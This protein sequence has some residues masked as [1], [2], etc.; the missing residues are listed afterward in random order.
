MKK[1]E[2][3]SGYAFIQKCKFMNLVDQS[4]SSSGG[5]IFI[6]FPFNATIDSCY[7]EKCQSLTMGGAIFVA[8]TLNGSR[9]D[10]LKISNCQFVDCSSKDKGGAITSAY[11]TSWGDQ[12]YDGDINLTGCLFKNCHS[13]LGGALYFLNGQE[14]DDPNKYIEHCIFEDCSGDNEEG[15][16]VYSLAYSISFISTTFRVTGDNNDRKSIFVKMDESEQSPVFDNC[17]FDHCDGFY[18]ETLNAPL[19]M[20]ACT[21]IQASVTLKNFE[22]IN[23]ITFNNC[24]FRDNKDRNSIEI[25]Q[26]SDNQVVNVIGCKFMNNHNENEVIWENLN[27]GCFLVFT[28]NILIMT[29]KDCEFSEIVTKYAASLHVDTQT[30]TSSINLERCNFS[31]CTSLVD[32]KYMLSHGSLYLKARVK[33]LIKHCHFVECTSEISGGAITTEFTGD[34]AGQQNNVIDIKECTF[35]SCHSQRGGAIACGEASDGDSNII[36]C[37]F[38]NC[39]ASESGGAIY[40]KNT[41]ELQLYQDVDKSIVNCTFD[42][43]YSDGVGSAI[44]SLAFNTSLVNN[45]FIN[46][47][48]KSSFLYLEKD[49]VTEPVK[50]IECIFNDNTAN[51]YIKINR[52]FSANFIRCLFMQSQNIPLLVLEKENFDADEIIFDQCDFNKSMTT[53]VQVLGGR[54]TFYK[55]GFHDNSADNIS[56]LSIT[57][58]DEKDK[59]KV[60]KCKFSNNKAKTNGALYIE[61]YAEILSGAPVN[62]SYCNF[63]NNQCDGDGGAASLNLNGYGIETFTNNTFLENQAQNGGAI[64]AQFHTEGSGRPI[65]IEYCIFEKC[66]AINYGGAFIASTGEKIGH[67]D[68]DILMIGCTFKNCEA[69][70]GGAVFCYDGNQ[71]TPFE[72]KFIYCVFDDNTANEGTCIYSLAY[73]IELTGSTFKNNQRNDFIVINM[74][75]NPNVK[76]EYCLFTE[77]YGSIVVT[78]PGIFD[79][80]HCI[81]SKSS[82]TDEAMF[83]ASK[84]QADGGC[85]YEN[86]TFELSNSYVAVLVSDNVHTF[87]NCKFLNN[88]GGKSDLPG[89]I[90]LKDTTNVILNDCQFIG[91]VG[92]YHGG[93]ALI[94]ITTFVLNNCSFIENICRDPSGGIDQ[95]SKGGAIY[96]KQAGEVMIENCHFIRNHARTS[97]GAIFVEFMD[98]SIAKLLVT[99]KPVNISN[100]DFVECTTDSEGGAL[101]SGHGDKEGIAQLDGDMNISFCSFEGCKSQY[102]GAVYFD[103][104]TTSGDEEKYLYNCT[105]INNAASKQGGCLYSKSFKLSIERIVFQ[106]NPISGEGNTFLY[107]KMNEKEPKIDDCTFINNSATISITLTTGPIIFNSCEFTQYEQ[108]AVIQSELLSGVGPTQFNSCNVNSCSD[109]TQKPIQINTNEFLFEDCT[110]ELNQNGALEF[111][112]QAQASV[113]HCKFISNSILDYGGAIRIMIQKSDKSYVHIEKCN[114]YSNQCLKEEAGRNPAGGASLYISYSGANI[115]INSCNFEK[116]S[117]KSTGGSILIWYDRGTGKFDDVISIT[118]STFTHCNATKAGGAIMCG[119]YFEGDEEET[120]ENDGDFSIIDCIFTECSAERGGGLFFANGKP[121]NEENKFIINCTFDACFSTSDE[122]DVDRRKGLSIYC[123]AYTV[124]IRG[125]FFKNHVKCDYDVNAKSGSYLYIHTDETEVTPILTN[126]TF[127][128]NGKP[129]IEIIAACSEVIFENLIFRNYHGKATEIQWEA[130]VIDLDKFSCNNTRFINCIFDSIVNYRAIESRDSQ[131]KRVSIESCSITNFNFEGSSPGCAIRFS[132][133]NDEENQ[134]FVHNCTF[135]NL[136]SAG[137]GAIE[138]NSGSI[139]ISNCTFNDCKS[140]DENNFGGGGAIHLTE[141][142]LDAKPETIKECIFINCYSATHGGAIFISCTDSEIGPDDSHPISIVNCQFYKCAAKDYGGAV[143]CGVISFGETLYDN[144]IYIRDCYFTE[145]EAEKGGAVYTHQGT[146]L[147]DEELLISDCIFDNNKASGKD[148]LSV[149]AQSYKFKLNGSIFRNHQGNTDSSFLYVKMLEEGSIPIIENCI[150]DNNG[151][152]DMKIISNSTTTDINGIIF[153]NYIDAS[154]LINLDEWSDSFFRFNNCKFINITGQVIKLLADKKGEFN[155]CQFI[156]I[157]T[158]ETQ[159][160]GICIYA[161]ISADICVNYC[162]FE[163]ITN[164]GYNGGAIYASTYCIELKHSNFTNCS[165]TSDADARGGAV[166]YFQES[167]YVPKETILNCTFEKCY[168]KSYGGAI[169]IHCHDEAT[170]E[171]LIFIN[172]SKFIDCSSGV[173][174]GAITSGINDQWHDEL[175]GTNDIAIGQ[176]QFIRCT[177]GRGGALYFQD[178]SEFGDEETYIDTCTFDNCYATNGE[179]YAISC[180]SYNLQII[181]CTFKNHLRGSDSNTCSYIYIKMDD[182]KNPSLDF[183]IFENNGP[184][185]II[186]DIKGD[187]QLSIN[188]WIFQHYN[189]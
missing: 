172:Q 20:N 125:C 47:K 107:I 116:D 46:N 78:M 115:I 53:A 27:F 79:M 5:A 36:S 97:G 130:R 6:Q 161:A 188:K 179:G 131:G 162:L 60:S 73:D 109:P 183:N 50:I 104:G 18:I 82:K 41:G 126:C 177:S 52:G 85:T 155:F 146:Q 23:N 11:Y 67:L 71:D 134:I 178:G 164:P 189:A 124:E 89:G 136:V 106:N 77:N 40:F 69:Q 135:M 159:N 180:R 43:C 173:E 4:A 25:T 166:Y 61:C 31:K 103:D 119:Q 110:F 171:C 70:K 140:F 76:I 72:K 185:G 129:H 35:R 99:Q 174:G 2:N 186:I 98:E 175:Y 101:T 127:E 138:S 120:A 92:Y 14:R 28:H 39:T 90:Q 32:S 165:L 112:D 100:C 113:S 56:A 86:V 16:I 182:Y 19:L 91:N 63:Q 153:Q 26:N 144:D 42:S 139:E 170:K 147:G 68:E 80:K 143:T 168:S 145:C 105:F 24:I 30:T 160:Q 122:Y 152:T 37:T 62:V 123:R 13:G 141:E 48:G 3:D 66:K 8:Y 96:F 117:S 57:V 137:S 181:Y 150:F 45:T 84:I 22:N 142:Y 156:N 176:C 158:K 29:V 157:T 9:N 17:T 121:E 75:E 54:H 34:G 133:R 169:F 15:A 151:M 87:N 111:N 167:I 44:S 118:N 51:I 64:Y 163:N 12:G 38:T 108:S 149:Y 154:I 132:G 94:E 184:A 49:D 59:I 33:G 58:F 83:D 10:V 21:F 95:V 7:F 1:K 88:T 148:G 74:D 187:R 128:D 55:C 81:F 102:G 114:F 65:Y 93:A